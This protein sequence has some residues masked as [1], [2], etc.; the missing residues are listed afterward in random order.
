MIMDSNV[1]F[2]IFNSSFGDVSVIEDPEKVIA[3]LQE[4][5]M[6][7][8][9][10]NEDLKAKNE[11][12]KKE[13]IDNMSLMK[14]MS[15]V[16]QRRKFTVLKGGE[17]AEEDAV[18]IAKLTNE[19][20]DLQEIN[21]KML[22]L[23]KE[24]EMD[25][26]NLNQRFENYRM[27]VRIENDKNMER[28]RDL[29]D[30]V[31]LLEIEKENGYNQQDIDDIVAE[32][33]KVKEKL[34]RQINEYI[35]NIVDLK[36]KI[37]LKDR[38][39]QKLNDDI[40][41]LELEKLNLVNQSQSNENDIEIEKLKAEIEKLKR[42]NLFLED[43]LKVEKENVEKMKATHQ[44]EIND[45]Q[46][47]VEEEQANTKN[48]KQEK[49]NEI[50][51]LKTELAK[52]KK[53]S[54]F[55]IK[56]SEL[57]EKKLYNEQQKNTMLQEKIDKKT[58]E[59][60][61]LN[62]LTKKILT[63]KDNL[64][65]QQ[66]EKIEEILKDKN[67]LL[68]QNKQ[69]LN[70][71]LGKTQGGGEGNVNPNDA[72]NIQNIIVENKILKEEI[73]GLKEQIDCQAKDLVDVSTYEKESIRLKQ[74]NEN[75]LKENKELKR[76]IEDLK[77]YKGAEIEDR[78]LGSRKRGLTLM[79]GPPHRYVR[80]KKDTLEEKMNQMNYEKKINVLKKMKDDE[81]KDLEKQIEKINLELAE[82]KLKTV[83]LAYE[84]DALRIKYKNLIKTVTNECKKKGVKLNIN[85]N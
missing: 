55:Y 4:K 43:K 42:E 16:G 11:I 35:K 76:K 10:T 73:K 53:N 17:N 72:K 52:I 47:Q 63:N 50:H 45:N 39:I 82:I 15:Y 30:K 2:D 66:A 51:L 27:E 54:V 48:V 33:N 13:N 8:E 84:N 49:K 56:R 60:E 68:S 71:M 65:S 67:E 12:L 1:N 24:K 37:N 79:N 6:R 80:P 85:Y 64:L 19:R 5:V 83:D 31:E 46:K 59:L 38:A 57:S 78:D 18:I 25:I 32:C 3:E 21:E 61:D 14:K 81:K 20:D 77:K 40:Q 58:K 28:I 41:Q 44:K 36:S 62:V 29:E 74:E 9:K 69:L 26:E 22:D 23:L 75:Y 70:N 34:R 7:L